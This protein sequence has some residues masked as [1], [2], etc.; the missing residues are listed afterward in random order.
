MNTACFFKI[1]LTVAGLITGLTLRGQSIDH[2]YEPIFVGHP[3]ENAFNGLVQLPNGELRHYGF[4]GP[5]NNPTNY[6]F[7][8]SQDIGLT[9]QKNIISKE[10]III[11]GENPASTF[12]PYSGDFISIAGTRNGTFVLRSNTGI[13][14]PYEKTKIDTNR[15]GMIR[16]P[17]FLKSKRRI[18]VSCSGPGLIQDSIGTMQARVFYSDDDGYTWNISYVPTGPRFQVEWPHKKS[19][20]QNY[21]IEPTVIEL[22]DG[23]VWMLLRTSMDN[24][25]ESFSDDYGTTWSNPVA[26]RFYSTLTM[27]TLF[28]LKDGRLLLFFCN[29]TPLPEEDRSADSTL[30]KEQKTGDGWEDVF[31]N[32]DAIHAAISEDDGKSWPGFRELFLNPLRNEPDFATRG[33]TEVS[34]DKS[35]H[36]SQA[37]ELPYGKVLLAFG[38]HPLVRS[39]IIFDPDWLNEASVFDDFS[40]GLIKW[41]TFKYIKGIKGHCAY[42]RDPGAKLIDHPDKTGAKVLQIRHLKNQDLVCDVDGAV[43]NFPSARE[44]SFSTRIYLTPGSKGGRISLNDRWFNPTDTLTHH[45]AIYTI[46]FDGN[47]YVGNKQVF[48]PGR[49]NELT[50]IWDNLQTGSCI[51]NIGGKISSLRIPVNMQ[52]MNGINYVHFQSDSDDEDREGYLI[53]YV[54][55]RVN[56]N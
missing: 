49:W 54:K 42:N 51:L 3:P 12:S 21:A 47:G 52:S 27:P 11:A 10:A 50:F 29:T 2:V 55:A 18:L 13:D 4:E 22:G 16:Q 30:R 9:W 5:Q 43:W 41:S 44:G 40:D 32:R 45:F 24:L 56:G 20:W 1:T 19:R 38:Q 14:G 37:V 6:I 15:H 31:T 25:Y 8:S 39:M 36:Q 28:R 26:S 7:I 17:I 35:V 48:Q 46:K 53:E 23:R 34:L 33:G